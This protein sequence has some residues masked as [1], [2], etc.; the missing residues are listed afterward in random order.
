MNKFIRKLEIFKL[1]N[2]SLLPKNISPSFIIPMTISEPK[3]IN[4]I[5]AN[6][7][8][9]KIEQII[10]ENP[11]IVS[12]SLYGSDDFYNIG[13]LENARLMKTI[14]PN[15]TMRVYCDS[16]CT[17]RKE[18][19]AYGCNIYNGLK[20]IPQTCWRF[21]AAS[22][23]KVDRIIFRDADS[24]INVRERAAVA[25]WILSNK[26]FHN[27]HDHPHHYQRIMAGMW[28]IKKGIIDDIYTLIKEWTKSGGSNDQDFLFKHVWDIMKNSCLEHTTEMF[29]EHESYNGFVGEP[30]KPHL[31]GYFDATYVINLASRKD[32]IN[33]TSKEL[34][35]YGI[36]AQRFEALDSDTKSIIAII[37]KAKHLNLRNVL[38]FEDDIIIS[39]YYHDYDNI[40][41]QI[42]EL[43]WDI[44]YFGCAN[45]QG[46]EKYGNF[47]KLTKA[48]MTLYCN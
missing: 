24:R 46:K 7:A 1:K 32:R 13:A 44:I 42:Q 16:Q 47:I 34:A 30:I 2:K 17:V 26:S 25:A 35:K 37:K 23:S 29:P 39:K 22:D 14:Y 28:G 6:S 27:I 21:L 45:S 33:Q 12:F 9:S 3:I 43:E 41:K 11:G 48:A 20:D 5:L 31:F 40:W 10:L 4:S 15:W 18:L 38:I 36:I 19:E 8:P